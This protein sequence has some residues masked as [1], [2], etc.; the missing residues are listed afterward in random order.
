MPELHFTMI[1]LPLSPCYASQLLGERPR[2]WVRVIERW[3]RRV[4][5]EPISQFSKECF[6]HIMVHQPGLFAF[7]I[8]H[9]TFEP[10]CSIVPWNWLC[11]LFCRP[12]LPSSQLALTPRAQSPGCQ[13]GHGERDKAPRATWREAARPGPGTGRVMSQSKLKV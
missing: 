5:G 10:L 4:H 13:P 9:D 7:A 2:L 6:C 8:I 3:R 11:S 1:H 12:P